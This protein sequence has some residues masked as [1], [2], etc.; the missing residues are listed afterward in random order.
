MVFGSI[1]NLQ[2]AISLALTSKRLLGLGLNNINQLLAPHA[3][4]LAGNRLI[5]IGGRARN[6]D[7]LLGMLTP[8]EQAVFEAGD[9]NLYQYARKKFMRNFTSK[10]P[11]TWSPA[12]Y[13]ESGAANTGRL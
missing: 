6:D 8:E 5:C 3:G 4:I 13:H 7:M 2:D 11:T 9:Y 12:N 1:G 10:N